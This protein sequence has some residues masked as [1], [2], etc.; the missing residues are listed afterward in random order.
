MLKV[1]F[2]CCPPS[3]HHLNIDV[4]KKV[5]VDKSS[6]LRGCIYLVSN[7][8][9]KMHISHNTSVLESGRIVTCFFGHHNKIKIQL[10]M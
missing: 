6:S 2:Q 4:C 1:L 5:P 10:A 9:K 7:I 8:F 3:V